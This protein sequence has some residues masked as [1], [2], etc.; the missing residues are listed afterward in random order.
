MGKQTFKIKVA[1]TDQEKQIGLSQTKDLPNDYGMLFT[2]SSPGYYPFWMKEM[3]YPIDIIYIK[4]NK[5]V[6]L[7]KNVPAPKDS[8]PL[9][10]YVPE[11][12]ADKVFE[13]NAGLAE[14]YK[15]KEGDTIILKKI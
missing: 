5:V 9:P 10:I 4:D 8:K 14:K 3:K 1:Q 13:I 2:F 15:I 12:P 11:V 7:Y 6:K